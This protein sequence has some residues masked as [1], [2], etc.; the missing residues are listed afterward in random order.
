MDISSLEKNQNPKWRVPSERLSSPALWRLLVRTDEGKS[1]SIS[2]TELKSH[3]EDFNL[4]EAL[5]ILLDFS[6]DG[7]A[8]IYTHKIM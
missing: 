6:F 3:L 8:H 2:N 1:L 4:E 5:F 7:H